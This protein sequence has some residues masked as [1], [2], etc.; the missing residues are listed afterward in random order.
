MIRNLNDLKVGQQG[1]VA[2]ITACGAAKRRFLDMGITRGAKIT[3]EKIA[4]FGDPIAVSVRGYNLSL[5]RK[6][7]YNI[8]II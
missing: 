3:I 7:A 5:R 1:T 8:G 4:P 6:E 2:Q